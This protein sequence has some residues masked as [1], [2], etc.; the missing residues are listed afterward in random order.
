MMM[1]TKAVLLKEGAKKAPWSS[2]RVDLL[3]AMG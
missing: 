2:R 3:K 1:I